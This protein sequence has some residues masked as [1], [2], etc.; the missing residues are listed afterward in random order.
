[1]PIIPGTS[2]LRPSNRADIGAGGAAPRAAAVATTPRCRHP[3]ARS[4]SPP[5]PTITR[6]G[7]GGGCALPAR[8]PRGGPQH[9]VRGPAHASTRSTGGPWLVQTLM[10]ACATRALAR[11]TATHTSTTDFHLRGDTVERSAKNRF[12]AC[13]RRRTAANT[14]TATSS[15]QPALLVSIGTTVQ[16]PPLPATSTCSMANT[17]PM[18]CRRRPPGFSASPRPVATF[19]CRSGSGGDCPSPPGPRQSRSRRAASRTAPRSTAPY[20]RH[21]RNLPAGIQDGRGGFPPHAFAGAGFKDC[22]NDTFIGDRGSVSDFAVALPVMKD[23]LAT[24]LQCS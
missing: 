12:K 21:A 1:V 15:H 5:A 11:P 2:I 6:P 18:G 4:C 14:S 24:I 17:P 19:F 23:T 7:R 13:S 20:A 3:S 10:P 8:P 22:G 16:P 9:G